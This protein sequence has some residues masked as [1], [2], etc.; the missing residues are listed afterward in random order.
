[1][2]CEHSTRRSEEQGLL[3]LYEF[4]RYNHEGLGS[5]SAAPG[6][7][8]ELLC[9]FTF[10]RHPQ[11]C[12][13]PE[14]IGGT[15]KI[16]VFGDVGRC[17]K[18]RSIAYNLTARFGASRRSGGTKPDRNRSENLN[19]GPNTIIPLYSLPNLNSFFSHGNY[20]TS[21]WRLPFFTDDGSQRANHAM[22]AFPGL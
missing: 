7:N 3:D 10:T 17:S 15:E 11:E 22:L 8:R 13:S 5:A 4:K 20:I 1:M 14:I 9:H 6:E 18:S 2:T 12:F 16:E 21:M 19:E